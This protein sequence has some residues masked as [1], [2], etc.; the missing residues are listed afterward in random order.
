MKI[1]ISQINIQAG[2]YETKKKFYYFACNDNLPY[3][4]HGNMRHE[5]IG[6][7]IGHLVAD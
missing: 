6:Q 2:K 4:M 1:L 3:P 7:S 5:C